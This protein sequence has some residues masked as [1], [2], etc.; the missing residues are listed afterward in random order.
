LAFAIAISAAR[1]SLS[2]TAQIVDDTV[3][4]VV[5]VVNVIDTVKV[6]ARDQLLKLLELFPK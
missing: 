4:N 5:N 1:A 3:V 2:D 6:L